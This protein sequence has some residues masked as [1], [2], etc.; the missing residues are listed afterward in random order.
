LDFELVSSSFMLSFRRPL[1]FRLGFLN[2]LYELLSFSTM[3]NEQL[4]STNL[5]R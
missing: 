4:R 1:K 3:R 5:T 2:I